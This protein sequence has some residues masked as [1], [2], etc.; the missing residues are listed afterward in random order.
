MKKLILFLVVFNLPFFSFCQFKNNNIGGYTFSIQVDS[1]HF[2]I[3]G[4]Q[5]NK[6]EKTKYINEDRSQ[7]NVSYSGEVTL[8]TNAYVYNDSTGKLLK[9]FDA[10]LIGVFPVIN[11]MKM[12]EYDYFYQKTLISGVTKDYLI[13]AVKTDSYNLDNVLDSDDPIQ[14]YISKKDGSECKQITS[15]EMNITNWK[16]TNKG[17]GILLS[18]Q[19]DKNSDKKFT[20]DEELFQINLNTDISK[21]KIKP[22][23]IT[24]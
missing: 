5:P 16:L 24:K 17:L 9:I 18:A 23:I 19:T 8:W 11:T 20:E 15:N 12:I 14:L 7:G 22:V 4:G 3:I 13:F 2:Y 6:T 10:P 1:S 21:I